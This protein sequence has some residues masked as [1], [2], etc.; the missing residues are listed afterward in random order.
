M[1][2]VRASRCRRQGRWT[3]FPNGIAAR[4][5]T[6]GPSGTVRVAEVRPVQRGM[7]RERVR[8]VL[9]G[10][11]GPESRRASRGCP[12][13]YFPLQLFRLRSELQIGSGC[14]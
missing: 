5:M 13:G 11:H 14:F 8:A 2:S 3:V 12:K 10:L 7:V 4:P 6:A 1:R 9:A